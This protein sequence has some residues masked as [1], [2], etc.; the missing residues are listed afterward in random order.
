MLKDLF[1]MSTG[2]VMDFNNGT[3]ASFVQTCIGFDPYEWYDE[4]KAVLLRAIWLNEPFSDVANH[5]DQVRNYTHPRQQLRQNIALARPPTDGAVGR[6]RPQ[7]VAAG[8]LLRV[9]PQPLGRDTTGAVELAAARAR[10]ERLGVL[11]RGR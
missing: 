4:S 5:A 2:C 10:L 8:E 7:G 6:T 9:A 11:R 1:G 3:F